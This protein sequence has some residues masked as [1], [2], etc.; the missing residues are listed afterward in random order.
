ME[1]GSLRA[2]TQWEASLEWTV[3]DRPLLDVPLDPGWSARTQTKVDEYGVTWFL[4]AVLG[5]VLHPDEQYIRMD[6]P[7]TVDDRTNARS[8]L[9]MLDRI[10]NR[11]LVDF[12]IKRVEG[13]SF[14]KMIH[15]TA[16]TSSDVSVPSIPGHLAGRTSAQ[17]CQGQ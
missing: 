6:T 2:P 9:C 5:S 3:H 8:L 16:S 11:F 15:G 17:D 1:R 13:D 12:E 4:L 14:D 10:R 7:V